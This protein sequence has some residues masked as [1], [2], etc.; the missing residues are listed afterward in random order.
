MANRYVRR[1]IQIVAMGSDKAE[2]DNWVR[3]GTGGPLDDGETKGTN[4]YIYI[5]TYETSYL[6]KRPETFLVPY[7]TVQ[8]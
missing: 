4:I 6:S 1:W 2:A 5:Y 8:N 7:L 3:G